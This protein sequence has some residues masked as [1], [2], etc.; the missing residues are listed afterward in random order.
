MALEGQQD[1]AAALSAEQ[2]DDA[3]EARL[4]SE[5]DSLL[6]QVGWPERADVA[7]VSLKSLVASLLDIARQDAD[8]SERRIARRL[9]ADL[10]ASRRG[11]PNQQYQEWI[12][13]IH[14][15]APP[16]SQ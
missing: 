4:K 1:V 3:R 16:Q 14:P 2:A 10:R 13:D 5:A 15:P 8:S 7:L 9:L 6:R 11:V 12:Q